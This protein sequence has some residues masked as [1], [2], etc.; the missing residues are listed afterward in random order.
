MRP[1]RMD[2]PPQ[3]LLLSNNINR[4]PELSNDIRALRRLL[5]FALTITASMARL[6]RSEAS[7][8]GEAE[9]VRPTDG[10]PA[11]DCASVPSGRRFFPFP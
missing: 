3:T 1:V 6:A 5:N 10:S 7:S 2:W 11:I 4:Y 9:S 8:I